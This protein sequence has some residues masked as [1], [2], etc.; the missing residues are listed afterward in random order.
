M[1]YTSSHEII[2][3]AICRPYSSYIPAAEGASMPG[4]RC[5]LMTGDTIHAVQI[6]ECEDDSEVVLQATALLQAKPEHQNIEIWDGSRI[7]A[8]VPRH[9]TDAGQ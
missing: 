8:R 9:P 1:P 4:Y 6:F 3:P 5:Y 2:C 7:V